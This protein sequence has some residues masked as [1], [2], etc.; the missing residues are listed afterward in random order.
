MLVTMSDVVQALTEI[1]SYHGHYFG[2]SRKR[3]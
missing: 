3:P 1:R 2:S